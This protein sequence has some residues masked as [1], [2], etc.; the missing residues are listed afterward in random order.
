MIIVTSVI[1]S[2]A[3]IERVT[4]VFPDP[5][6]PAMPITYGAAGVTDRR[7][8]TLRNGPDASSA[9]VVEAPGPGG[10][11]VLLQS[12]P[13]AVLAHRWNDQAVGVARGGQCGFGILT[14]RNGLDGVVE[15]AGGVGVEPAGEPRKPLPQPAAE[16]WHRVGVLAVVAHGRNRVFAQRRI[17]A[18]GRLFALGQPAVFGSGLHQL[19]VER[20]ANPKLHQDV[21]AQGQV[22]V[23]VQAAPTMDQVKAAQAASMPGA[24]PLGW[25][26][27]VVSAVVVLGDKHRSRGWRGVVFGLAAMIMRAVDQGDGHGGLLGAMGAA[28]DETT[29]FKEYVTAI[30]HTADAL[31][32]PQQGNPAL[33]LFRSEFARRRARV[34]PGG[35]QPP[36]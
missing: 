27:R 5:E 15:L 2:A 16:E 9:V 31:A 19:D 30:F 13:H 12:D 10:D 11:D 6:P 20:V 26:D 33:R 1:P 23:L 17:S 25:E 24:N 18:V 21:V 22:L 35:P 32:A 8:A 7:L 3:R 28:S 4:V 14:N 29:V 34:P 36:C